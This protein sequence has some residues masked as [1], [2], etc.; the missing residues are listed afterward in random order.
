MTVQTVINPIDNSEVTL[1]EGVIQ[2]IIYKPVKNGVDKFG[3]THNATLQIDGD[4]INF[5]SM[6]VKEGREP[7]LQKVSGTAPNLQWEDINEGD[8]VKVVV[9]VGEYNGKPQYTSGTSKINIL[10]KGEGVSKPTQKT[11]VQKPANTGGNKKVF[12]E[13]TNITNGVASVADE[14]GE[15]KVVLGTHQTEVKVGGRVTAFID[16]TGVIV[17]GFKFY[18]AKVAKDDLGIKVGNSFSVALEAGFVT[19][20]KDIVETLPELVGKIDTA[21]DAVAKENS[22]MDSYAL[23]A[24]FGQSVVSAARLAKK[25]TGIDKI[26][27]EAV[28]IFN[29]LNQVEATVR[30]GNETAKLEPSKTVSAA[31]EPQAD[32]PFNDGSEVDWDDTIPF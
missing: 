32:V 20:S 16:A 8:T 3:N 28:V 24:R 6:K 9:K 11:P 23:G 2:R 27:D 17:S 14:N 25:G 31:P 26:L 13:I 7:Q 1:I 5:I 12:G 4:Y 19:A 22:S 10:K 18:P 21:R 29:A 15:V 30:S